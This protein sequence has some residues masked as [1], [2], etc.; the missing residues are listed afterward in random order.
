MRR[1]RLAPLVLVVALFALLPATASARPVAYGE[2]AQAS[3][4][5]TACDGGSFQCATLA[6]PL[7]Y[8]NPGGTQISI[9]VIRRPAT[10]PARRIG[11]LL[12]NP[13]GPGGSAVDLVR[14][15]GV[16]A[17]IRARFDLVGFDP[18]GVGR[19]TKLNCHSTIQSYFATDP[20]PDSD[21]EWAAFDTAAAVFASECGA[22]NAS[23][24]AHI[25]TRDVARDMD[26][27]RIALG[28]S[29]ISYLGYSYGTT[30]G[31]VYAD[32]F[33]G[34]LR[35]AVLDGA[36]DFFSVTGD[37]QLRRQSVGFEGALD[38]F[39][40]NCAATAC[41]LAAS[42]DP[43]AALDRLFAQVEMAPIPAPGSDRA[44]GPGEAN[45]GVSYGLYSRSLWGQLS[46]A[47]AAALSGNGSP[48]VSMADAYLQRNSSGTYP[49]LHE[50]YVAVSCRDYAWPDTPAA[51]R[52]LAASAAASAPHFGAPNLLQS[53]LPCATWPAPSDPLTPPRAEGAPPIIVIATT[54]DPA[55]PYVEG[56]AHA[57]QLATGVLLTHV[58]EGHTVYG[59][60]N[61]CVN[62][63]V[64]AYLLTLAVPADGAICVGGSS[65]PLPPPAPAG[66]FTLTL[67]GVARGN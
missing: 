13:G 67:P 34:N 50:V 49:N 45:L 56:V 43:R 36:Y 11:V 40:A 55:T 8:A 38:A 1:S 59:Q 28:E 61:S 27:L 37:E 30:L 65:T 33:P 16:G 51:F 48:L 64:N 46:V 44:L 15:A 24:L 47:T 20:S 5:W 25:G 18:R 26:S 23:L 42:G 54:N 57:N 66:P 12:M 17:D 52:A 22:A 35:A 63:V 41:P 32:M 4:A 6:V 58:G 3:L 7:D 53:A 39:L 9:G 62:S 31:A 19:S 10:D 60:G 29:K 21:A 2:S 14:G